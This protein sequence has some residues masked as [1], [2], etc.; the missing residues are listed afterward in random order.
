MRLLLSLLILSAFIAVIQCE[1]GVLLDSIQIPQKFTRLSRASSMTPLSFIVFL[2]KRNVKEMENLFWEVSNPKSEQYGKYLTTEAIA[3]RFGAS[4]EAVDTVTKW[5]EVNEA[6][7]YEMVLSKDMIRVKTTVGVTERLFG[8]TFSTF[9]HEETGNSILSAYGDITVPKALKKH[10]QLISGLN[11][12]HQANNHANRISGKNLERKVA[13]SPTDGFLS[14]QSII[15]LDGVILTTIQVVC[16]YNASSPIY[17]DCSNIQSLTVTGQEIVGLQPSVVVETTFNSFSS[18]KFSNGYYNYTYAANLFTTNYL[19]YNLSIFVMYSNGTT[20]P[21][22]YAPQPYYSNKFTTPNNIATYYGTNFLQNT[23][24]R[25][26][27]AFIG[28][29]PQYFSYNDLSMFFEYFGLPRSNVSKIIGNN[30]PLSPGVEATLDSQY[31]MGIGLNVPTWFWSVNASSLTEI[32][33]L[34]FD[35]SNTADTDIPFVFSISY[36]FYYENELIT[37][38]AEVWNQEFMKAG[39]RGISILASSGDGG[40]GTRVAPTNS[41]YCQNYQGRF[42]AT[43]PYVTAVGAT[44]WSTQYSPMC[45]VNNFC[46]EVR[47]IACMADRGGA[48]TSSGGFSTMF[49]MP[50]YQNN[51]VNSYLN[52]PGITYPP[53][54]YFNTSNRAYPDVALIG[55]NYLIIYNGVPLPVSGTSASTP[56]FAA[57]ISLLNNL[58]LNAGKPTLGFLNPWLYQL[59]ENHPDYFNDIVVGNNRCGDGYA[60]NQNLQ[61]P[62]CCPDGFSAAP[63]WDAVTGLGSPRFDKFVEAATQAANRNSI[64]LT[65]IISTLLLLVL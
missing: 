36:T 33:D 18:S 34:F 1:S 24:S 65:L 17:P 11:G 28:L 44:M 47:E 45:N 51:I 16:N 20:S 31:I 22:V 27:Q 56:V 4:K 6:F 50:S 61:V 63:G 2:N 19:P 53:S 52:S 13:S 39:L 5:L 43:S 3:E 32:A 49:P 42:P 37:T 40:V 57:M 55:S 62:F 29:N 9:V 58:R 25:N 8:T 26:K 64:I 21:P 12:F 35:I 15:M 23:N 59:Y 38:T 48:I 14:F 54:Q 41:S 7:D 46:Q 60:L 30:N 10:I